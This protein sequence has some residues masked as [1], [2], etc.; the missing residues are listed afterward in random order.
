MFWI[1]EKTTGGTNHVVR[2]AG[3]KPVAVRLW[4]FN[5]VLPD[6]ILLGVKTKRNMGNMLSDVK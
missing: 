1:E 4:R 2:I 6:H 5:S 3:C